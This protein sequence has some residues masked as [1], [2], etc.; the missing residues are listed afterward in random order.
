MTRWLVPGLH[1]KRWVGVTIVAI[2][3]IALGIGYALREFYTSA[4]LPAFTYGLTLQFW[5]RWVRAAIFLAVGLALLGLGMYKLTR[6]L[7]SPFV[8]GGNKALV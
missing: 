3:G 4:H 6:S 1:V 2:V 7:L 5:P 8:P